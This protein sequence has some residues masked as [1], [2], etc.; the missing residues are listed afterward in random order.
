MNCS[1]TVGFRTRDTTDSKTLI[2]SD[3]LK[4]IT[5]KGRCFI[6]SGAEMEETQIFY[7]SEERMEDL[8]KDKLKE[9]YKQPQEQEG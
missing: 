1:Q 3:I 7:I 2:N 9:K 5:V 4:D 6:D 8:L